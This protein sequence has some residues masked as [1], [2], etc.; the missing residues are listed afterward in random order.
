MDNASIHHGEEVEELLERHG[1]FQWC[2]YLFAADT[3][4][5]DQVF[6]LF[7]S[8]LTFLTSI[9]LRRHSPKSSTICDAIVIT[10]LQPRAMVYFMICGKF[11]RSSLWQ[12]QKAIFSMLDSFDEIGYYH[13]QRCNA[14]TIGVIYVQAFETLSGHKGKK[15][16]EKR[17]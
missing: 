10:T 14:V 8:L 6:V 2:T 4:L 12:M 1:M 11:L 5:H 17:V 9:Q 16:N 15:Y 13:L 7:T 3:T